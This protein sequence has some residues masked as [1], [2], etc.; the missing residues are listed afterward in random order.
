VLEQRSPGVFQVRDADL[1]AI[2]M[3]RGEAAQTKA[4]Q[5]SL[6][7]I[8]LVVPRTSPEP[9]RA[10]RMKE[11]ENLRNRFSSCEQDMQLVHDMSEV[12]VKEPIVR[13]STDLA[14]QY[15]QLL[16]KTPDGKMTPPEAI[17]TGIELVAICSR[18]EVVAD[19][20]SR[21]EFK[22]ELLTKRLTEYEKFLLD[23]FRKQ[24]IIE[25]R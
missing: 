23:Y 12:V 22:D 25:Y 15:K 18:K 8:I 19:V 16:D 14:V 4:T 3:A 21:R 20:S 1:V 6:Q 10:G 13:L 9:V 7:Q 17:A 5:Y 2:L 11:A 24:S